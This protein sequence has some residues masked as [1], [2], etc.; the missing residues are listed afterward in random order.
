MSLTTSWMWATD[1]GDTNGAFI[2]LETKQIHWFDSGIGCAC[3]DSAI[4]QDYANFGRGAGLPT[5]PEDILEEMKH[6]VNQSR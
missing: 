4:I 6:T 3:S 1:D 5:V 2:D